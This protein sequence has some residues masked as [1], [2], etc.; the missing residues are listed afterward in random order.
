ML[1]KL[2]HEILEIPDSDY[3]LLLGWLEL[4]NQEHKK[5]AKKNRKKH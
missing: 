4:K 1:H 3:D 5:A 2:P